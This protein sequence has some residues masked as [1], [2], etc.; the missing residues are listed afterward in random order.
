MK[1][2][3]DVLEICT[4]DTDLPPDTTAWIELDKIPGFTNGDREV[5]PGDPLDPKD[6]VQLGECSEW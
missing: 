1:C 4:M 5:K 6:V 3:I 2:F